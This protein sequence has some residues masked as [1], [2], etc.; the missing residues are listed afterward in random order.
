MVVGSPEIALQSNKTQKTPKPPK[1]DNPKTQQP[2]NLTTP[3]LPKKQGPAIVQFTGRIISK[4]NN[5]KRHRG[6][7]ILTGGEQTKKDYV[8]FRISTATKDEEISDS[9][10]RH[11]SFVLHQSERWESE[12]DFVKVPK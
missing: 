4:Y 10:Q 5:K 2:Q 9:Y 3:K 12:Y 8:P 7:D 11:R 1:F 6:K